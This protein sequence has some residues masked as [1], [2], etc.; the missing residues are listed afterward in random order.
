MVQ[1][2]L[3]LPLSHQQTGGSRAEIRGIMKT[4]KDLKKFI[5]EWADF[6]TLDDPEF[7]DALLDEYGIELL[8]LPDDG[9]GV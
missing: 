6:V 4:I 3:L 1:M 2:S 7:K 5:E 9:E 8:F